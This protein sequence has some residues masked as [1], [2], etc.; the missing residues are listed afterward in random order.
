[1]NDGIWISV[2]DVAEKRGV[3]K[4]AISKRL[5]ALEGR[6]S[7]RKE[8]NRLLV[9]IAEYDKVTGAE[10]DPAQELRNREIHRPPND[11]TSG[12]SPSGKAS[13]AFSI[14][15][16]KRES[17]DAE[18]ARLR[19]EELQ[20]KLVP[21]AAVEDAMVRCATVLLRVIEQLPGES[22]DP[23]VRIILKNKVHELRAALEREMRLLAEQAE[24]EPERMEA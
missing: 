24:A 4:Q 3:S 20:G 19:L 2:S 1:M 23:A 16:A 7:T 10:T 6:V 17:Y 21:V 8:G 12:Q 11:G 22:D 18:M 5:K 9:N 13:L 15:R 14:Q